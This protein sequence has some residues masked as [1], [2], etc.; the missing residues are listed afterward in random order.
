MAAP[1]IIYASE[2]SA[3]ITLNLIVG[4]FISDSNINSSVTNITDSIG[5][6]FENR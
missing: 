6:V 5:S 4:E 3:E 2:V 1:E